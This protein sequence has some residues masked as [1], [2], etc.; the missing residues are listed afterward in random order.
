MHTILG[1]GVSSGNTNDFSDIIKPL[2][3][4]G[5]IRFI[6]STTYQD[7]KYIEKE[8]ALVRRFHTVDVP[9]PSKEATKEILNTIKDEYESF[10]SIAYNQDVLDSVID[11]SD[12]FL[13]DRKFPDKAIDVLDSVGAMVKFQ[14][15]AEGKERKNIKQ[16]KTIRTEDVEKL[17]GRMAKQPPKNI[18]KNEF[19]HLLSVERYLSKKIVGQKE[20]IGT[21][22]KAVRRSKSGLKIENKPLVSALFVGSTGVGKTELSKQ[23]AVE[24]SMHFHRFDMSEYQEKHSV[25]KFIG[26]PPG[27]VGH[28]QGG[29]FIERVRRYPHAVILLDEIEKAHPDIFNLLLQIMDYG[30]ITDSTGLQANFKNTMII[31]TSNIGVKEAAKLPIGFSKNSTYGRVD[32]LN[33]VEK[34]F[35]PEFRNRLDEIVVFNNLNKKNI[36]TIVKKELCSI[37]TLLQK[38]K[39]DF[40]WENSVV[41]YL[42]DKGYSDLYGAR[43]ILRVIDK[44]VRDFIVEDIIS[45][46]AQK[47]R[48]H[49]KYIA[50]IRLTVDQGAIKVY[51]EIV[52]EELQK[53]LKDNEVV[54]KISQ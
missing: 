5:K 41:Y 52:S 4:D 22:V 33:A 43:S 50:C 48:K 47:G 32:I 39:I 9:E 1:A 23:L 12:S 19:L 8:S 20:A 26:S 27:Y 14:S 21:I 11:L 28:E 40:I 35:S 6:A 42:S 15:F 7:Y 17:I 25:A 31:M 16:R 30:V 44:E 3:V 49:N 34:L 36:Q 45:L 54:K 29:I 37:K 53:D 18:N 24:M 46:L 10:Y 13:V 38:K 51:K 2:L